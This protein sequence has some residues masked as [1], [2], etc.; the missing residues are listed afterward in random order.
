MGEYNFKNLVFEGGGVKGIAY[1]GA[2]EV[3]ENKKILSDI[4]RVAG[5]SAG[6]IF[7]TLLA[8]GYS[9]KEMKELFSKTSF[10]DF[11]DDSPF[12][13]INVMRLFFRYGWFKGNA[14]KKW[15]ANA[16]SLKVKEDITFH[17]L[18]T[19]KNQ[20]KKELYI[21]GTDVN[22]Q[23][24]VVFSHESYPNMKVV[25]AVRIS[26]SIPFFFKAIRGEDYIYVDGG[27]YYNYPLNLFDKKRFMS[28]NSKKIDYNKETLGFRVDSKEE[29]VEELR[30]KKNR[31]K[32]KSFKE[33][34][35]ALVG[36]LVDNANKRHLKDS[37]WHRT[38]FLNS[39]GVSATD[40]DLSD[41]LKNN[42]IESGKVSTLS[43]FK[44]FDNPP[45]NNRPLNK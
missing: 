29:I 24:S 26:M 1:I 30:N 10:S 3:L 25:D 34:L 17:E 28:K 18:F 21:I 35:S 16:I 5:T 13:L 19:L 36:G 14:F 6:A 41:S 40:F 8:V 39:L 31:K 15:L 12:F 37:D 27:V 38:I 43:Y 42:L 11:K 32:I 7:A 33:Y 9:Y 23:S 22:T 44:W 2:L 4:E 20:G 45:K